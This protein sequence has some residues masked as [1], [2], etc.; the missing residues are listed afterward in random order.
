MKILI[1]VTSLLILPGLSSLNSEQQVFDDM[2][3][4]W[5]SDQGVLLFSGNYFAYTEFNVGSGEFKG[6]LGGHWSIIDNQFTQLLEFNTYDKTTVGQN[7][8]KIYNLSED[9]LSIDN[10]IFMRVDDGSPGKLHGAWLFAGRKR[11]GELTTRDTEQ[12]RKTMKILSGK[13]F[14]WIAYNTETGEFSGTGGGTYTT[15][16]D[17]YTEIIEFFSRDIT[18]VGATLSFNFELIEGIWHHQGKNSRGEP[19]YEIWSKRE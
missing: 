3:G 16:G 18:R 4:A 1:L 19:L 11:D 5:Q 14:Q 9:K 12:P 10:E 15:I 13:R 17:E 8:N 7:I 6:T 2:Q